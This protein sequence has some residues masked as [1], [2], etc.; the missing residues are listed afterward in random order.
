M[1]SNTRRGAARGV[2]IGLG[3][4]QS[5]V[6]DVLWDAGSWITV[7]AACKVLNAHDAKPLAY[8]TIKTVLCILTERGF[9]EKRRIGRAYEYAARQTR[10]EC[11][12]AAVLEFVRPLS[13][14][15]AL[16]A[17]LIEEASASGED[18]TYVSQ[19]IEERRGR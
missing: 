4:L 3:P 9:A 14:R 13:G 16:I 11:E 8:S 12:S 1:V 19:L 7:R 6:M 2:D 5:R 18:L 17:Q 10:E 15:A